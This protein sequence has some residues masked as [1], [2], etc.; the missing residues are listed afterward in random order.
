[1]SYANL[2]K[3]IQRQLN[4]ENTEFSFHQIYE[5]LPDNNDEVKLLFV[6][7]CLQKNEISLAIRHLKELIDHDYNTQ[8]AFFL[9]GHA[10]LYQKKANESK[11]WLEKAYLSGNRN[12][13]L[14]ADLGVVY[15]S[16]LDYSS[17][18]PH[19]KNSLAEFPDATLLHFHLIQAYAETGKHADA[20]KLAETYLDNFGENS[21][22]AQIITLLARCYGQT[23]KIENAVKHY[24]SAIKI[25]PSNAWAYHGLAQTKKIKK[26][27]IEIIELFKTAHKNK[28]ISTNLD[29]YYFAMGKIFDDIGD[30]DDAY[31]YFEK[32]NNIKKINLNFSP[33]YNFFNELKR[34]ITPEL[35]V[36]ANI[37]G[38]PSEKPIFILG[39]PRSGSTL[40]EQIISTHSDVA[41]AG[42]ATSMD[43]IFKKTWPKIDNKTVCMLTELINNNEIH[44]LADLYLGSI[45]QL[46]NSNKPRIIDKLPGNFLLTG[47][48]YL[49]FPHATV[50]H[51]TRHPLDNFIS[52]YFQ[53]FQEIPWSF[54][55]KWI[56]EEYSFYSEVMQYWKETLP[57]GFITD[58]EYES[59]VSNPIDVSKT[60]M[61]ACGLD[62]SE[63]CLNFQKSSESVKTASFWQVR[64]PIYTSSK[65]RWEN[66][67]PHISDWIAFINHDQQ[68]P[69]KKPETSI[70]KKLSRFLG[71]ND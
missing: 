42:E 66:Y 43:I 9:L 61:N 49:L 26:E 60:I 44:E 56:M 23:G 16:L 52:C 45:T 63:E 2:I 53:N 31:L 54:D 41:S 4:G 30:Y 38:H 70:L 59:L 71:T 62:W 22:T 1:M 27:D 58:I 46:S 64:Q 47:L 29:M 19:L 40:V 32:A 35:I 3:N 50:I 34:V 65:A 17:A 28:L 55:K 21:K 36:Q 11:I 39:M 10:L 24:F 68:I 67:R 48:I 6:R 12:P 37:I 20:I 57:E 8:E 14:I 33:N 5:L 13:K 51:T 15:A 7:L 25:D 69:S 18:I